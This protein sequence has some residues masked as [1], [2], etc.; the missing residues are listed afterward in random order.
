MIPFFKSRMLYSRLQVISLMLRTFLSLTTSLQCPNVL[1]MYI[2]SLSTHTIV[3][4]TTNEAHGFLSII[5]S[6][7]FV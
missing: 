3:Y 5:V 7:T 1:N 4:Y 6:K 2:R